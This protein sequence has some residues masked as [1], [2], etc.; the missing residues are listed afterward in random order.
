MANALVTIE[1]DVEVGAAKLLGW[2]TRGA[3][4]TATAGP[5]VIAGL[6][7]LLE[8]L[9]NVLS[10]TQIAAAAPANLSLDAQALADVKA[11]WP[12]IKAFLTTLGI[13]L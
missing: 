2:I 9:D 4:V 6:G 7:T 11:V 12:D 1:K 8:T 13:K 10:D 5:K 3:N